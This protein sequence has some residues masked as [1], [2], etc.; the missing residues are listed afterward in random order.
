[1]A[2]PPH[3]CVSANSGARASFRV[4]P[5]GLDWVDG[6][7][8]DFALLGHVWRQ[9]SADP[10]GSLEIVLD[11]RGFFDPATG[12]KLGFG[13]SAA[14]AVALAAALAGESVPQRVQ[15][16]ALLAHRDFQ[17]GHGSGV[18]VATSAHGGVIGYR[19]DG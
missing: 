2:G 18:D 12:V 15:E 16:A 7:S 9:V 19:R 6:A 13:S 17:G 4:Q 1:M 3:R 10:G 11:T 14:L 8:A 5:S